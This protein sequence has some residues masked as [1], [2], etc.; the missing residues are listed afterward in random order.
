MIKPRLRILKVKPIKPQRHK[1]HIP[2]IGIVYLLAHLLEVPLVY[3]CVNMRL[4]EVDM[5]PITYKPIQC[6]QQQIIPGIV[7][8][9][10]LNLLSE[11]VILSILKNISRR[12][13]LPSRFSCNENI[14]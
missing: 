1:H 10:I 8:G 5:L 11:F 14:V 2:I 7:F 4:V 3:G 6:F 12:K 13:I 9:L